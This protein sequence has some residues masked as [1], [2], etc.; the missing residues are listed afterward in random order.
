VRTLRALP[1]LWR[2]GVAETVAYRAE[3]LVWMLTTTI[4]LIMLALWTSVASEGP[5]QSYSS[6]DFV[7]YF[8]AVLIVRQLTSNWVAWQ[9]FE[10]IRMGVMSMRLLRPIHPF[11]A[12]GISQ[13]AAL[14]FRSLIAV[15]VAIALLTSSGVH[16]LTTNPLQLAVIVPSIML[17]WLISFGINF[18]IGAAGFWVTQAMALGSVFF[19][20]YTLLSGYMLPLDI[21]GAKYPTITAIAWA[22][23]FPAM[24]TIPVRILTRNLETTEVLRLLAMEAGW[25]AGSIVIAFAVWRR[26][27]RHYEAVGG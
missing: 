25:A 7:A 27:L 20:L 23:P 18:A 9:M 5:F 14:P 3:F 15:P 1:T 22:T 16:S 8:L 2:V 24:L 26:G 13:A 10:D 11:W 17:A 21:M 19:T 6:S 4:P 12:Y